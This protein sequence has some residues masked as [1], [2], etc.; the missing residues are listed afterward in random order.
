MQLRQKRKA[1]LCKEICIDIS[2]PPLLFPF[3]SRCFFGYPGPHLLD[4]HACRPAEVCNT[5]YSTSSGLQCDF[6]FPP[7]AYSKVRGGHSAQVWYSQKVQE[8]AGGA[9][10]AKKSKCSRKCRTDALWGHHQPKGARIPQI[11]A[12]D[13]ILWWNREFWK[14]IQGPQWSGVQLALS[15]LM[16]M[17]PFTDFSL[18]CFILTISSLPIPGFP[19]TINYYKLILVSG[20]VWRIIQTTT[21]PWT[22]K[23]PVCSVTQNGKGS[24]WLDSY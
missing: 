24:G 11:K 10:A 2:V 14:T 17:V 22:I 3:N 1:L 7:W 4:L 13:P 21:I 16:N 6:L 8:Q 15:S 9:G 20:P 19:S 23:L 12:L 5:L 18:P